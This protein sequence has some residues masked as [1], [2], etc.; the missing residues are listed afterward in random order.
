MPSIGELME[1]QTLTIATQI[2]RGLLAAVFVLSSL[3]HGG[4]CCCASLSCGESQDD[5]GCCAIE[6]HGCCCCCQQPSDDELANSTCGCSRTSS[7]SNTGCPGTRH[8]SAS[9]LTEGVIVAPQRIQQK[10]VQTIG[11]TDFKAPV[12][13]SAS[14]GSAEVRPEHQ[15]PG[16]PCA[17]NLR[18][19]ILCVWRN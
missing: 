13:M 7:P 11:L 9:P 1:S 6:A 4:S 16:D 8:C 18:Q 14:S 17:H 19:A 15:F 5:G 3:F 10:H 12:R 2:T